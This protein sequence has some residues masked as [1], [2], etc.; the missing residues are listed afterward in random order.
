MAPFHCAAALLLAAAIGSVQSPSQD[1]APQEPLARVNVD[2]VQVDAIVTDAQGY[3]VA[4]LKPE[5]FE[6]LENGKP[7]RITNFS[8]IT[9]GTSAAISGTPALPATLSGA[10]PVA[11]ARLA[12]GQA[13]RTIAIVVDDL[14]LTD[15]SFATVHRALETFVEQQAGPADLIAIVTTSGRLGALQQLTADKRLLRAAVARFRSLP[16]HRPGV[17][18]SDFTCVWFNHKS[19]ATP[20]RDVQDEDVW[21]GGQT[22]GADC[23]PE[24]D[25]Q[26]E[27]INDRRSDYYGRLSIAAL[28]H[29]VDGLR[30]LPGRKSILLFSEGMPL[31]RGQGLGDVNS[32]L[33]DAYNAFLNHADRSG[34]AVNTIDPRGLLTLTGMAERAHS[35]GDYCAPARQAELANSQQELAEM[36]RRTGGISIENN[37]DFSAA[38]TRVMND[39]AG[40]YL[41]GY[42]PSWPVTT[43]GHSESRFRKI[44][45]RVARPGL[46]VR[47]HSSLYEEDQ[48]QPSAYDGKKKLAAAILSPFAMPDVRLRVSAR[49]WD[50]GAPGLILDA[51]LQIDARDLNFSTEAD[52]RRQTVFEVVAVAYG[53]EALPLETFEKTYTVSLTPS[54]Y[55]TA[56][57]EGLVQRLELATKKPGAFQIRA[58]VRDPSTEHIGSAGEFLEVPDLSHGLA[59]S[60]IALSNSPGAPSLARF[61]PGQ[62]VYYAYQV[63]NAKPGS[64]SS[65]HVETQAALFHDGRSLGAAKPAPLDTKDQPDPKRLVATG[66]FRLG[67]QLTS[68]D[69]TFQVTAV[70]KNA[71]P[72]HATVTQSIDFEIN[73]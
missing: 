43:G 9:A 61:H 2:L 19:Q 54:A 3:H 36:A 24:L 65:M 49:F 52:G 56:L 69:Y 30:E 38:I 72:N 47:F 21:L 14:G 51:L 11:P 59:L 40:Y 64:E 42:H 50:A 10:P 63:L 20:S 27:L 67:K 13:R 16:N 55:Q 45:M 66:D 4:D 12:P 22:C 60:G 26:A 6:V 31:V 28:H 29:V 62:I 71:P 70:D 18:D 57:T 8:F 58:A 23:P 34:V 1:P 25:P 73:Q 32:A 68:G 39:Q 37:N 15:H 46:T 7:Q 5:D 41:I 33:N 35:G 17:E 53:S 48:D 44:A